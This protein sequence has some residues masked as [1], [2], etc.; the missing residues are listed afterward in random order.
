MASLDIL[1]GCES[2][3][4][5]RECNCCYVDK[6]SFLVE[7]LSSPAP[8]VSLITRPRRFGKTLMLSMLHEFFDIK[9]IV[10]ICLKVFLLQSMMIFARIG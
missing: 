4:K 10:V 5:L 9:K 8:S 6:T 3:K 2:F 7:M 1:V